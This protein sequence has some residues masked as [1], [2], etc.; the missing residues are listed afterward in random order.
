MDV[1]GGKDLHRRPA[2]AAA[3]D[4]ACVTQRVGID[5]VPVAHHR[6]DDPQVRHVAGAEDER[7]LTPLENGQ[8]LFQGAV[9]LIIAGDESR[10]GGANAEA[11]GGLDRG[12]LQPRVGRQTQVVTATED[13]HLAA[14]DPH[15]RLRRPLHGPEPPVR[16]PALQALE[17]ATEEILHGHVALPPL[18]L[19]DPQ[20]TKQ[21]RYTTSGIA[22]QCLWALKW[23]IDYQRDSGGG[24]LP[25]AQGYGF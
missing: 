22:E 21:A 16:V 14:I 19:A 15:P 12:R 3:V 13:D 5:H 1:I 11:L 7:G 20:R 10:S 24:G 4:D 6:R 18:S 25:I 23:T 8:S 17:F 2:Q 9:E